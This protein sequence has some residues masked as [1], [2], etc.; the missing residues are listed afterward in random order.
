[1]P[2]EN[3]LAKQLGSLDTS[4]F[5]SDE[6][7][8]Y[9]R[10][11]RDDVRA[12]CKAANQRD[13]A[14][15]AKVKS[16]DD[17]E[18]F[19]AP[20]IESLKR[21]LGIFPNIPR[22][23]NAHVTRT[24]EGDGY[25]IENLVYE[26]RAG[27]WVTA[28]LY[29][30][31]PLR[32]KM[33]AIIIIHSHHNPKTQGE[34]QDMGMLWARVGCVVMVIEQPCYGE[35]RE[36]A[37]GSRQDYRFRY[38]SGTQ[39]HVMGDS[40]MGWMVWDVM[41]GVDL[42]LDRGDVD[43][44]KVIL[45][46]AVAGGGDPSAVAA[47]IDT[48]ITCS[49]PF[50]FGG[51]QP[52]TQYPLPDD[53]EEVFNYMGYGYWESTRNLRLSGQDGF[54]PWVI[55]AS[56]APRYLIYAHEFSW[57]KERD[58]AWKRLQKVFEFYDASDNLAFTYGG[59]SVTGRPPEATHCNNIGAV[60][61]K[62]IYPAL[63]RWFDIPV[64][65]EY[66]NRL[67]E[68][69][70]MCLTPELRENLKPRPLH[71]LLTEIGTARA[72]G[73]RD[74]L[75]RLTPD[76]KRQCLRQKWA[77]LLGDVE[78]ADGPAIKSFDTESLG[79]ISVE[80]IVLEPEPNIVLPVL[81]LLPSAEDR[82]EIPVVVALA[83]EGKDRFL[84]ERGADIAGLLRKGIAVYLTDVRGTGE[85]SSG[86]S[87]EYQSEAT[88]I[89][90]TELML[91]QTLLGSQLRDVRSVLRY[92]RTRS[93]LD[94]QRTAL[95]GDS[96]ARAN[97]TDFGDPLIGEDESPHQSAPLGGLLALLGALYEDDVCSVVARGMIAGYQSVLRDIFCYVPYDAIVPGALTAGDLCDI[98]ASFAPR[99]LRLEALVDGRNCQILDQELQS[100][101]KPTLEA[102]QITADGLS[103]TS[104]LKKDLSE[105]LA[106]SL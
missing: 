39:L 89:S 1:M 50:N 20:R 36:H 34:L 84:K 79:S 2:M 59:G 3:G 28:N 92:L 80:S 14:A 64:P 69:E 38:I 47:A 12:R 56:A 67:T 105:W 70:L 87:R 4:I 37:P 53:A 78:P 10:M 82:G 11:L 24:I 63:E 75:A 102:Y 8:L 83:Q 49:I 66:Q 86:S 42:L 29:V 98:A 106:K 44:D 51:P 5:S 26:S 18:K 94:V 97:P 91:G 93:E 96:F 48:R 62:M 33:P 13:A 54:L 52:E 31:A 58:P 35:Q 72:S 45:M 43:S 40:L 68:E 19:C 27:V 61:R 71:V 30:P 74:S 7:K 21:S 90:A 88:S 76:E 17:W 32:E 9:T 60:H 81:G 16:K 55:V 25:S 57:D 23:L 100:L 99:P 65:D 41:R 73:T 103:L 6:R 15:W 85:T 95:W 101:F 46:G 77:D 104:T 22:D